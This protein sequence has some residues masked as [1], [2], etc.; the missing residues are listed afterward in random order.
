MERK[1][2]HDFE[3]IGRVINILRVLKERTDE[4]TTLSQTEILNIMNEQEYPCSQRTLSDYLKVLMRVLNPEDDDG[5]VDEKY[6]IDDY[7]I[8]PKG[9]ERKL[10]YRDHGYIAEGEKKLQLRGLRYN[11]TFS[12][13]ELN[14]LIEAVLFLKDIDTDEKEKLIR[15]LQSLSSDNFP[16]YSPYI[17]E[18][19][20]KI[21]K[22]I[23][24]VFEDP[25]IDE[26][27]AMENLKAIRNAIDNDRQISFNF[28]GYNE[29]KQL[30]ARKNV[31]GDDICYTVSPYYIILYNGK[32]YLICCHESYDNVS[33][34]RVDLMKNITDE[35]VSRRD[36]KKM[37]CKCRKPKRDVVGL[38][39]EWNEKTASEFQSEH[40]YM[41]YGSP[42]SIR[43]K[44]DNERYTL[45]HDYFGDRYHYVKHID[46]KWDEVEVK[47]VPSAMISWV[48]QCSDY[49]EV[50]S[51]DE[52][53]NSIR[54]KCKSLIERYS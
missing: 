39:K 21:S 14:K 50:L 30:V 7:K 26:A 52:L 15:K 8:I 20:K 53:R 54:D 51:P 48:M 12:F 3:F 25:K 31:S 1:Y 38:P 9:L 46:E 18:T 40:L 28:L 11:H 35:I 47:C 41:F 29:N 32:Y 2:V 42:I 6:T 45:L 43:L 37:I 24:G 34:Y 10:Y 4:H 13:A 27:V 23:V 16:K 33:F 49:V 19:T 44:I 36:S 5:Y 22:D 17:S